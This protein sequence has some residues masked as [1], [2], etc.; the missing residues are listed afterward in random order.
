VGGTSKGEYYDALDAADAA[1][2]Q[3]KVDVTLME[4]MLSAYLAEQLLEIHHL[5]TGQSEQS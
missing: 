1:W 2:A 3:Q 4:K 5:A